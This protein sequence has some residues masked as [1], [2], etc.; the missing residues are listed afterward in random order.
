MSSC[1]ATN[2]KVVR[3]DADGKHWLAVEGFERSTYHFDASELKAAERKETPKPVRRNPVPKFVPLTTT[4]KDA[5]AV[6]LFLSDLRVAAFVEKVIDYESMR[7][8]GTSEEV[9]LS[10]GRAYR[11]AWDRNEQG[12]REECRITARR[13]HE[14]KSVM[15]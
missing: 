14:M 1:R 10:L 5:D 15:K 12:W 13:I 3:V 4:G 2:A 6:A 11:I 7:D 9:L 8:S